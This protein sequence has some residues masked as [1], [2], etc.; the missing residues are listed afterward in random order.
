MSATPNTALAPA[1]GSL[2]TYR[3]SLA[4]LCKFH[5]ESVEKIPSLLRSFTYSLAHSSNSLGL[6]LVNASRMSTPSRL[7][8]KVTFSKAPIVISRK[9][10][11][12][13]N[14]RALD[15]PDWSLSSISLWIR[16]FH[17]SMLVRVRAP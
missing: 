6:R 17:V 1:I 13:K 16:R 14:V 3:A 10:L 4:D 5:I 7:E 11:T 12:S 2:P 9:M 8:R 15:K